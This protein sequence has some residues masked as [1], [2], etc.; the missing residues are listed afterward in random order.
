MGGLGKI[1]SYEYLIGYGGNI[2]SNLLSSPFGFFSQKNNEGFLVINL[3]N[4]YDDE[5]VD[6]L[7]F[8][9]NKKYFIEEGNK[10]IKLKK[11]KYNIKILSDEMIPIQERIEIKSESTTVKIFYFTPL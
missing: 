5:D 6:A 10:K 3:I 4:E 11:G 8:V 9:E 7:L 2:F 1:E